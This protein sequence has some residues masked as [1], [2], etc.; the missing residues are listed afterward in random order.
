MDQIA[1]ISDIHSNLPALETVLADIKKR[2]IDTIYCLGDLAGK[3]PDSI[4]V[5]DICREVCAD[6]VMGNWDDDIVSLNLDTLVDKGWDRPGHLAWQRQL[7][8]TERLAYLGGLPNTIE[9]LLSGKRVRLF[10]ASQQSVHQRVLFG[11][12]PFKL[13][14][15]FENTPF[16]TFD[17]PEPDIVGYGDIHHAYM[18]PVEDKTLFNVG[19]V[20]NPMDY[21]PMAGY[22]ILNGLLGSATPHSVSIEFV[23]L[24]YSINASIE[25]AWA[26]DMPALAEY[27]FELRTANHRSQ[28]PRRLK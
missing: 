26:V 8:G 11:D 16:T 9:L 1:I 18:L 27:E 17:Q 14:G 6:V 22:A 4:E 12:E 2:G 21:I 15:M 25:R 23:R 7:L 13:R 10:H 20:G 28:I 3:G 19:S 24:P 5:I